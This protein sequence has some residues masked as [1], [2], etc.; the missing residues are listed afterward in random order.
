MKVRV[1]L[2]LALIA[3]PLAMRAE[4]KDFRVL[5]YNVEDGF[6]SE[7]ERMDRFVTWVQTKDPDIVFFQEMNKFTQPKLEEFAHRYGHP[8]A[9]LS[10]TV[11]Y[12]VA[13]TSKYP[14][15][16]VEKV[17]DNMTHAYIVANVHGY[18]V[19]VTHLNPHKAVKRH[20][21]I[22]ELMY[23]LSLM[24]K[25]SKVIFAG[26]FNSLNRHDGEKMTPVELSNLHT[27]EEKRPEVRNLVDGKP[28]YSV[29]DAVER[30]GMID[31]YR[32]ERGKGRPDYAANHPQIGHRIDYIWVSGN[33]KS[34][35]LGCDFIYDD[36][37]KTMS[38]HHPLLMELK[39]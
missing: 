32:L 23:R 2:L 39:E 16:R 27:I 31:A 11:G 6:K 29:T 19:V 21:E 1:L 38:D 12:P 17:V 20:T 7:P 24:P 13:I 8:Y 22:A 35:V 18:E 9:V 28:D 37:T 34:K 15:V 3:C 33:L 5:S 10:K 25:G 4:G 30:G 36:V 14:I 26:D